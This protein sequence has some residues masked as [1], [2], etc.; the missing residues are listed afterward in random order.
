MPIDATP[1][2]QVVVFADATKLADVPTVSPLC[3]LVTMTLANADA[4]RRAKNENA[5]RK[6]F[7]A[8]PMSNP[9]GGGRHTSS[10][11]DISTILAEC[12]RAVLYRCTFR[13][14]IREEI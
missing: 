7:I 4:P 10:K 14:L 12:Y 9:W 13:P 5:I 8:I 2:G 3:G 1:L 6:R 11:E